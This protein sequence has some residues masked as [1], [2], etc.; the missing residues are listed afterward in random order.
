MAVKSKKY[1][2]ELEK[3]SKKDQRL[4]LAIQKAKVMSSN[5][6]ADKKARTYHKPSWLDKFILKRL[7][8]SKSKSAKYQRSK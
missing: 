1:R 5:E 7:K 2:E 3:E 6:E 4:S 8:R